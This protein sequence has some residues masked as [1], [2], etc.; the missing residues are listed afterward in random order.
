VS[1]VRVHGESDSNGDAAKDVQ[2]SIDGGVLKLNCCTGT[3]TNMPLWGLVRS[4][5]GFM[6]GKGVE[7][8]R[9]VDSKSISPT[10]GPSNS[11][12]SFPLKGPGNEDGSRR[13]SRTSRSKF[14]GVESV[15]AFMPRPTVSSRRNV[16]RPEIPVR[17]QGC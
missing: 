7:G 15:M 17:N 8:A 9:A 13:T 1:G 2:L 4:A 14:G 16:G 6:G 11:E 5:W 10:F 3:S 12:K